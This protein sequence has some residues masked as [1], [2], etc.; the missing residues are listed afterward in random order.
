ML[1]ICSYYR[2]SNL[3][4]W[5]FWKSYHTSLCYTLDKTDSCLFLS[6][7]REINIYSLWYVL[8]L[9]WLRRAAVTHKLFSADCQ[10]LG[11]SSVAGGFGG[12]KLAVLCAGDTFWK[13]NKLL[14]W[15]M[16]CFIWPSQ[17]LFTCKHPKPAQMWFVNKAWGPQGE[18]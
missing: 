16:Q 10:N 3:F 15:Q 14:F 5:S 6:V 9:L 7:F 8:L 11:A 1:V 17:G 13:V 2:L 18:N 12:V 4:L